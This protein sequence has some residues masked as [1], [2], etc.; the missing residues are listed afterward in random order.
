[1]TAVSGGKACTARFSNAW[2]IVSPARG[3]GRR[4]KVVTELSV[5]SVVDWMVVEVSVVES[6][7]LV[8]STDGLTVT[9][10]PVGSALASDVVSVVTSDVT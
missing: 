4:E 6:T 8:G 9:T 7:S 5:V 10:T 1:M 3:M 2:H